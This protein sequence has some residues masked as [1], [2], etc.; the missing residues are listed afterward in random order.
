MSADALADA[1]AAHQRGAWDEARRR[2]GELL[3]L[4]PD[5]VDALHLLAVLDYQQGRHD[6]ALAGLDRVLALAPQLA[7]AWSNKAALLR[8]LGRPA[9]SLACA[10]RAL[11]LQPGDA[12][13]VNN[14]AAALL[15]L[16]RAAEALPLL[17][18]LRARAAGDPAVAH[19]HGK[20]LLLLGRPAQALAAFEQA[21]ALDPQQAATRAARTE[22]RAA[23][24]ELLQAQGDGEGGLA[25]LRAAVDEAP[26]TPF[27]LGRWL[28][29]AL[30]QCDWAAL[31]AADATLRTAVAAGR[32]A[33][34]P[35]VALHLLHDRSELLQVA[36]TYSATLA[37]RQIDPPPGTPSTRGG[38]LR[39][40]FFSADWREHPTARLAVG[41][42][43]H[44]A[45]SRV[46]TLGFAFGPPTDD[47]LRRR[48]RA[49]FEQ[50]E[51]LSVLD[52][53]AAVQR[54]RH[55][56]LD[57]AID[58]GGPTR[59]ARPALFARRLAPL[60]IGWLG[61]AGTQGAAWFDALLADA[62]VAPADHAADYD[63]ALVHLPH[64]YQPNDDRR[65]LPVAPPRRVLGLPAHGFVWAALH[66]AAKLEPGV[67]S[68]WMRLLLARPGSVLWLLKPDDGAAKRLQAAA[69]RAGVDPGRLVFAPRVEPHAH[70]DR[71]AAADLFLDT[72][73][74]NAHTTASDA[75]WAGLPLLTCRGE[76]FGAR[77]AAS[78]LGAAGLPEL[79]TTDPAAYEALALELSVPG[80]R[81][82]ALRARLAAGRDRCALFD[83]ARFARAFE[84]ALSALWARHVEGRRLALQVRED[85]G[86]DLRIVEHAPV[87]E[88]AGA[89][90]VAGR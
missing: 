66:P 80:S 43:E 15:D 22:A 54:A 62:T 2:Y 88:A 1:L 65:P 9:E 5:H 16:G 38:R 27:L 26:H 61:F 77:V 58:L 44:L 37:P 34:A 64:C 6:D 69:A 75:L 85:P 29:A 49:A 3:A 51:D 63:E 60:Q 56:A 24:G 31:E 46:Q 72:F 42:I 25:Q 68:V 67:W 12:R 55:A 86:G 76:T 53:A 21:L 20:A 73:V 23:W 33:V 28:H 36:R 78:V 39:V 4:R 17:E 32:P 79:V 71:L 90:E 84:A 10:E 19:N 35:F 48:V 41:L 74:Y 81:L 59:D 82:A 50:F 8:D 47:A 30:K 14:R 40:G 83:T 57:I 89:D 11:V 87:A 7:P 18:T 45:G 70:L 52:D 13:A